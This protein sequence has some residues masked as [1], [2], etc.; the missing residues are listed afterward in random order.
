MVQ[1]TSFAQGVE[2]LMKQQEVSRNSSLKILHPLID[3][4]GLL[5]VGA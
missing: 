5:R 2:E 1:Q 3:Q 4:E